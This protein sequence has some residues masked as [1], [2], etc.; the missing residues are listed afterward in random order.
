MSRDDAVEQRTVD[1]A[2]EKLGLKQKKRRWAA[3]GDLAQKLDPRTKQSPALLKIDEALVE[4]ADGD[5][6]RLMIFMPPQEGKSERTSHYFP[7]W[8]LEH[9]PDLRI[10]IISYSDEMA[11]RWGAA[12]KLDAENYRGIDGTVDLH[13]RLREDQQAAGRWQINHHDGGVY[14]CGVGGA[15]TG[16][17]VDIMIIDDPIKNREEAASEA[18]RERAWGFWTSVALPRLSPT[19]RVILIQTRWHEDDLAG[20]ILTHE[21]QD[22]RV[23]SIPAIAEE[24]DPLGRKVGEPLVSVRDNPVIGAR[25][26][27]SK[28][29]AAVGEYVWNA[30]YQQRPTAAAGGLFKKVRFRYWHPLP[31]LDTAYGSFSGQRIRLGIGETIVLQDSWRFMTVDLAASTR[32]YADWSVFS[33]WTITNGGDLVLLDR[34]R[35]RLEEADHWTHAKPLIEKWSVDVV[36]VESRMFGTTFVIDGTREG[37][38]LSELKADTDKVTRS[39]PASARVDSG[40]VW[41][42]AEADW[43]EEWE[44]E[45]VSFPNGT[46]DDQVDTLSYAARVVAAYWSEQPQNQPSRRRDASQTVIEEAYSAAMGTDRTTGDPLRSP[47]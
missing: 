5:C 12:I 8:L 20:R 19:S 4:A 3:P 42:P 37:I 24:R 34:A 7:L 39:L 36:Y 11:R 26:N 13:I 15:L 32:S 30:L 23:I 25:R 9:N 41:F 38:P 14:C 35:M 6:D 27:W 22:W 31:P 21:S 17:P 18:Y 2:L 45:L 47:W 10:G 33:V 28:I 46:F 43:L 1:V 16:K 29:R 40:R 44:K